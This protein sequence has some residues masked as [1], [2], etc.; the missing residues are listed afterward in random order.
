MIT[1]FLEEQHIISTAVTAPDLFGHGRRLLDGSRAVTRAQDWLS[2][3]RRVSE[4]D[5]SIVIP[6]YNEEGILHSAVVDLRE[7]LARSGFV[8]KSCWRKTARATATCSCA[9]ARQNIR[10]RLLSVGEPNYGKALRAGV[11]SRA[12]RS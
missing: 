5:L 6:I 2:A 10:V 1:P 3:R 4:L 8:T 7:R 9:R 12:A 11:L